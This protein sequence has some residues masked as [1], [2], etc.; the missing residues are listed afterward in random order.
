MGD[1]TSYVYDRFGRER[2]RING[3]GDCEYTLDYDVLGRVTAR[4]DGEENPARY[5]AQIEDDLTGLYYL[6][7]RYYNT[8]IGRFT[9]EDVIYNDGLNLYA[10]CSSNPV[11]YEDPS[12]YSCEPKDGAENSKSSTNSRIALPGDADFVGPINSGSWTLAPNG[13]GAHLVERS[14]VRGRASLASFDTTDTPR[15]YPYGTPK[16]AGQA[17]IRLHEA[18]R[19]AGIKLRGGNPNLSDFELIERYKKAYN[20]SALNGIRGELRLPDSSRIIVADVIPSKA[21]MAL[22]E[23]EKNN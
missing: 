10:Y 5:N 11:M 6:R 1:K 21:F 22:L 9:Q 2:S 19:N 3:I 18:T 14:N 12:G 13:E 7:A 15:Y 4:T 16:S 20:N 17:H 8:G 23:W